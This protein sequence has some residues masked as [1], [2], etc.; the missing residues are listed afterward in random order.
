[1]WRGFLIVRASRCDVRAG[2]RQE[3]VLHGWDRKPKPRKSFTRLTTVICLAKFAL[4]SETHKPQVA[5]PGFWQIN[6]RSRLVQYEMSLKPD[7]VSVHAR[8]Q[9][10]V[11]AW[12]CRVV[13]AGENPAPLTASHKPGI[14]SC[15]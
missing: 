7:W 1:M 10:N 6:T 12:Q 3:R 2:N 9:P 8:D 15:R 11:A 5:L 14:G 13:E 4:R